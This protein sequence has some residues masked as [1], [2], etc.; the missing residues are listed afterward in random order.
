MTISIKIKNL[1]LPATVGVDQSERQQ[2]QEVCI[3]ICLT[4]ADSASASSD[5]LADTVDYSVLERRIADLVRD[6]QFALLERLAGRVMEIVRA[7][8]MVCSA[9]VEVAKPGASKRADSVS[10]VCTW[11]RQA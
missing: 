7:E 3:N 1:R 10:A 2:P 5:D 4:L 6:E 9:V 11:K 8:E